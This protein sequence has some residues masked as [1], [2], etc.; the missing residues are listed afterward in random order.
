M[1]LLYLSLRTVRQRMLSPDAYCKYC[2]D[3]I[4]N[5][6]RKIDKARLIFPCVI[7][8]IRANLQST[9]TTKQPTVTVDRLCIQGGADLV[10]Q[11]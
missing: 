9:S 2:Q 6:T 4:T 8:H 11:K 10:Y 5:D 3:R 7:Y 1:F